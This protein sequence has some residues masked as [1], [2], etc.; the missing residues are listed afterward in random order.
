MEQDTPQRPSLVHDLLMLALQLAAIALGIVVTFSFVF[1]LMRVAMRLRALSLPVR[2]P[3]VLHATGVQERGGQGD[4]GQARACLVWQDTAR[5]LLHEGNRYSR[6][7]QK[8][9]SH[10]HGRGRRGDAN[11]KRYARRR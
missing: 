4:V 8:V 1:G 2:Q 3:G 9:N 7:I 11:R 10:L 6:G 5:H